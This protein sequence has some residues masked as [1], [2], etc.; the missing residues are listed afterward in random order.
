MES[1]GHRSRRQEGARTMPIPQALRLAV[2]RQQAGRHDEAASICR[3]ILKA[4]PDHA[5]ALHLLGLARHHQGAPQEAIRLIGR[6]IEVNPEFAT[7]HANLAR[8]LAA[9]G[10][11]EGAVAARQRAADL[12]PDEAGSQLALGDALLR[13]RRAEPAR[14]AY[15]RAAEADPNNAEAR[16][17]MAITYEYEG[18]MEEAAAAFDQVLALAPND[19]VRVRRDTLLPPIHDSREAMLAA[20]QRF[21]NNVRALLD[22]DLRIEDPL[23]E[24]GRTSFYLAYHGRNDREIQENLARLFAEASPSLLFTAP[25]CREGERRPPEDRIRVGFLSRFFYNQTVGSLMQGLIAK[26]PRDRFEVTVFQPRRKPDPTYT[27]IRDHADTVVDLPRDLAA[28]RQAIATCRLDALVLAGVGMDPLT[29]F[30]AFARLAPV[31]CVTWGHPVTT[32]IPT[33][34]YF[35][36]CEDMEVDG[37]QEHYSEKLVLFENPS[38]CYLRPEIDLGD[39]SRARFG[40]PQGKHLYICPQ[41]LFKFHPE[42]D[43]LLAEVLRRDAHGELVL[44]REEREHFNEM[45]Q[46]RFART[47]PDVL[48]RIRWLDRLQRDDFIRLISV[49]DV[50]LDPLHF[51]GGQTTLEALNVATPVVT[52]PGEFR[53][54]RISYAY[55][56]KI[57]LTETVARDRADYV[58]IAHHLGTDPDFREEVRS[59]IRARNDALFE[60]EEAVRELGEFL[61]EAVER[62]RA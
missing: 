45:L 5:D 59:K 61:I 24:I 18:R 38:T 27:Y 15:E 6:A 60:D 36:S 35:I 20:R 56:R 22:E 44:I 28:A 40:L 21:E 39:V 1:P 43:D 11:S 54:S 51:G 31:Q 53:R 9:M 57:G 49:A 17:G 10:D 47:M 12:R 29:Y 50:M 55:L 58:R 7:F 8:V 25:H 48:D 33:M 41:A 14:R 19:G 34:D 2:E 37:A 4:Q 32:G 42:F 52:L 46:A 26:L 13:T 23:K 3:D 30:L 16:I 62:A